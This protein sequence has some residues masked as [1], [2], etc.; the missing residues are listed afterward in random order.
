MNIIKMTLCL[1]A[2]L[3]SMTAF[4]LEH[5]ENSLNGQIPAIDQVAFHQESQAGALVGTDVMPHYTMNESS[6]ESRDVSV[7]TKLCIILIISMVYWIYWVM[8]NNA[9][10]YKKKL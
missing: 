8:N 6:L 10:T 3:F 2:F 1:I 9:S 4:A 7:F 5:P